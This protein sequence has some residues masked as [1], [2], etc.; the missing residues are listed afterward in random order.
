MTFVCASPC[1]LGG[2]PRAHLDG[3]HAAPGGSPGSAAF[4]GVLSHP[5]PGFL[6]LQ[7]GASEPL[8]TASCENDGRRLSRHE[9]HCRRLL[10]SA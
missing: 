8:A 7:T 4:P 2:E 9:T 3:S 6:P 1:L 10:P 5:D